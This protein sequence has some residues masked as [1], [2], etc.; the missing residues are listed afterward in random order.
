MLIDFGNSIY[1]LINPAY[2]CEV[3]RNFIY[4]RYDSSNIKI[5][6]S[7]AN[8]LANFLVQMKTLKFAFEINWPLAYSRVRNRRRAGNKHRA[9]KIRQK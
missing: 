4:C 7:P 3:N 5:F 8:I 6:V 9:W 1:S 2:F